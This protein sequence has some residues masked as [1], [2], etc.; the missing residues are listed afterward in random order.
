MQKIGF[1]GMGNMASAMAKGLIA[2]G[3]LQHD[4]LYACARDW[5]KLLTNADSIGFIPKRTIA[6]LIDAVDTVIVA[7]KPYQIEDALTPFIEKLRDKTVLSVAAGWDFDRYEQLLLPGT[8]HLYIMPNTPVA[9]CEGVLM[10]EQE[11]SLTPENHADVCALL[12]H[13]GTVEILPAHLMN[14]GMAIAGCGPAFVSMMIEAMGDAGVAYGLPRKT[15]YTL[16]AQTLAGTGK[17]HLATGEHPAAM[18]DAV[19]SPAGTTI[20]G[21][22]HLEQS[23]FRAAIISAVAQ[24]AQPSDRSKS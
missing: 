15:A 9:V 23:G 3:A 24:C 12:R 19:C 1:I 13:L 8:Q 22:V 10:L 17:L 5:N 2:S 20:K 18:K 16:A 4:Q 7:I 21:V 14:A 6:E 11:H